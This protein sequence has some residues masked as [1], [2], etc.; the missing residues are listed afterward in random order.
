MLFSAAFDE[1][2]L[3]ALIASLGYAFNCGYDPE[4]IS[5]ESTQPPNPLLSHLL[6]RFPAISDGHSM[7]LLTRKLASAN[8]RAF[9]PGLQHSSLYGKPK[10]RKH[11]TTKKR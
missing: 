10:D 3:F 9:T 6:V 2:F 8:A 5:S 11:S 7:V 1:V 4:S